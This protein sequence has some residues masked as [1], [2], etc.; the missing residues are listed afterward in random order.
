MALIPTQNRV[1]TE[2]YYS[3]LGEAIYI[4][5]PDNNLPNL[6][7][8]TISKKGS[9]SRNYRYANFYDYIYDN[10]YDYNIVICMTHANII[11]QAWNSCFI[12]NH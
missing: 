7:I 1:K 8:I 2:R 4:Y 6:S 3:S 9:E 12:Y 10:Y 11:M 5:K